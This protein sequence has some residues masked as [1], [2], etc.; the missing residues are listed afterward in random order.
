MKKL[1]LPVRYGIAISGCLIAYF[2]ILALFGLHTKPVFSL[3]NTIITGFGIFEVIRHYKLEQGK[4]FTYANGFTAGMIA[5]FLAT[6]MFTFFFLL[7]AT[8]INSGFLAELL[9]VFN[10]DY[11]VHI[12]LVSFVVAVM[13]F[14]TTVI[15]TFTCMQYFKN[16]KKLNQNA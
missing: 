1:I 5:G 13:G 14:A 3:F 2:L 10:G 8:E 11:N 16:S 15:L 9:E 6:I 4:A 12:G 7:Y